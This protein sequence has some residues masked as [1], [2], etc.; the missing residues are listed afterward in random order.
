MA[1]SKIL[2]YVRQP[3]NALRLALAF[4]FVGI[5]LIAPLY[6]VAQWGPAQS[7]T[8]PWYVSLVREPFFARIMLFGEGPAF[9][10]LFVAVWALALASWG[11]VIAARRRPG[12]VPRAANANTVLEDTRSQ[13]VAA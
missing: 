1:V 10:P 11:I 9:W 2:T 7:P 6:L 12:D 3:R 5:L 13:K 4:T 8:A